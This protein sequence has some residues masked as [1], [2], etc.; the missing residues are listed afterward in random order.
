MYDHLYT[1]NIDIINIDEMK[2]FLLMFEDDTVLFSYV[3]LVFRSY[4]INYTTIVL[5]GE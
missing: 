4:R 5:N 1:D 3:L 2:L